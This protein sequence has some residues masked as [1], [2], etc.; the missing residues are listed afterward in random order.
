MPNNNNKSNPNNSNKKSAKPKFNSYWIYIP[1]GLFLLY[2]AFGGDSKSKNEISNTTFREIITT[3]DVQ[4]IVIINKDYANVY[5][6][7]E[8]RGKE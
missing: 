8:A 4:K 1:I 5:L 6:K 3:N 2:F 7:E